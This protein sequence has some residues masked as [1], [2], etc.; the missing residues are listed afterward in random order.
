MKKILN[1]NFLKNYIY[2]YLLVLFFSFSFFDKN[3][4][5]NFLPYEKISISSQNKK[6]IENENY[7]VILGVSDDK[8][9]YNLN[10][11]FMEN[12][13]LKEN[14]NGL[15]FIRKGQMGYGTD[16]IYTTNSQNKI[17][18]SVKKSFLTKIIF[19]NIGIS[20]KILVDTKERKKI[21]DISNSKEGE[22][23]QYFPFK[24]SKEL[25]FYYFIIYLI[26][27]IFTF[28]LILFITSYFSKKKGV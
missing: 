19:Y 1:R 16:V 12:K 25:A 6:N 7:I 24:E 22:V 10:K 21:F 18:L 9:I 20:P 14:V 26:I 2:I 23:I 8:K 27:A 28:F 17:I 11:I 15:N 4:F 5:I 3:F 13:K